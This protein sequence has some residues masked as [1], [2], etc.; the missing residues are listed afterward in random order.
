MLIV[1]AAAATINEGMATMYAV[2]QAA[3]ALIK[4]NYG[5]RALTA[6]EGGLAPD[7]VGAEMMYATRCKP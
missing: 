5:T 3:A 2:Y 6:D 7:F 1:P 4:R